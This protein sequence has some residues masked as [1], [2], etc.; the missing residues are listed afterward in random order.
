MHC[1]VR[2]SDVPHQSMRG[3]RTSGERPWMFRSACRNLVAP[4]RRILAGLVLAALCA[5]CARSATPVPPFEY[6]LDASRI[7]QQD[8][9]VR[10]A[11]LYAVS[12]SYTFDPELPRGRQV[13]WKFAGGTKAGAPLQVEITMV[14]Q[15]T[16][17][18]VL[19]EIATRPTLDS[20]NARQLFSELAAVQLA[21]GN[22]H[23][24]VA[25]DGSVAPAGVTLH[26]GVALA[27]RGK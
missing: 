3:L 4:S 23:L 24:H 25:V 11:G 27:Y 13:A 26:C 16:G 2:A 12:L 9:V 18:V 15:P 14:S 5:A 1:I 8:F 7:L 10:K 20:W 19:Q 21:P 22:Y 6:R 17:R